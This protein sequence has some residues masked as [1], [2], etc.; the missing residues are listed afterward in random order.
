M[1]RE[2]QTVV[3]GDEVTA[4]VPREA[5]RHAVV[6]WAR[7]YAPTGVKPSIGGLRGD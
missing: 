5:S 1:Q 2:C 7:K 6:L 4:F 3:N